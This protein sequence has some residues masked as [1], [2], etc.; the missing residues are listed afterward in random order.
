MNRALKEE[1]LTREVAL[2]QDKWGFVSVTGNI[3][4]IAKK[5][6][7]AILSEPVTVTFKPLPDEEVLASRV[8]MLDAEIKKVRAKL[9]VK[10][11]DLEEQKQR[12]LAIT[13]D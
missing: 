5:S 8:A 11:N 7:Y 9:T 12:L 1:D 3:D 2:Y 13:H 6:E 10:V 4:Y